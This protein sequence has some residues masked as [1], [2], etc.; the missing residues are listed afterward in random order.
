M[1][2]SNQRDEL[3]A[4]DGV[5][6]ESQARETGKEVGMCEEGIAAVEDLAGF[7]MDDAAD[8][9]D[10]WVERGIAEA[11]RCGVGGEDEELAVDLVAYFAW[12]I[13]ESEDH[14]AVA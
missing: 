12:E 7:F 5:I 4:S 10:L 13:E 1:E 14:D 8:G 3:R 2:S 6:V 9:E 11:A